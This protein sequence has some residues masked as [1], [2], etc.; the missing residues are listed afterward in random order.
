[1]PPDNDSEAYISDEHEGHY[2]EDF[3]FV[4]FWLDFD[5]MAPPLMVKY[6]EDTKSPKGNEQPIL[7]HHTDPGYVMEPDK[8]K[9][10]E[11]TTESEC[12]FEVSKDP[13]Q[14]SYP[15]ISTQICITDLPSTDEPEHLDA[16]SNLSESSTA[17]TSYELFQSNIVLANHDSDTS[18][19]DEQESHFR[20][21]FDS[22]DIWLKSEKLPPPNSQPILKN[23]KGKKSP[24]DILLI[25]N[26]EHIQAHQ[27][28]LKEHSQFFEQRLLSGRNHTH[29][30]LR[31]SFFH[32]FIKCA[33]QI[34]NKIL[35]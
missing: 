9:T 27:S 13:V 35:T 14:R 19:S 5:K 17:Q 2:T 3:D 11:N 33:T 22:M 30:V 10:E 29:C 4:D 32:F 15:Q 25:V 24:S 6:L 18:S 23:H 26:E 21:V 20:E 34:Q 28:I 31:V 12:D 8:Y 1:M 7:A 16:I